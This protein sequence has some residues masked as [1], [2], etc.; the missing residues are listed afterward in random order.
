MANFFLAG[1][2]LWFA[3]P[4]GSTL[5]VLL[6][7]VSSAGGGGGG[8]PGG[9]PT[10]HVSFQLLECSTSRQRLLLSVRPHTPSRALN[11]NTPFPP[12]RRQG[13]AAVV[14]HTGAVLCCCCC[15]SKR[16]EEEAAV[17]GLQIRTSTSFFLLTNIT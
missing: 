1:G 12:Y 16:A 3:W 10:D 5:F 9:R 13:E 6:C 7:P 17:V 2:V 4:G 8:G 14:Q 15:G 11:N